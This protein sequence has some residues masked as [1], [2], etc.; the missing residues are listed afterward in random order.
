V[1]H[2]LP[3]MALWVPGALPL[4]PASLTAQ[5]WPPLWP[6]TQAC[7]TTASGE[8]LHVNGQWFAVPDLLHSVCLITWHNKVRYPFGED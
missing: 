6:T 8:R 4:P 1:L 2:V 7:R 5:R 3:G